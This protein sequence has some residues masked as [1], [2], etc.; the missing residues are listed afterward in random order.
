MAL[1]AVGVFFHRLSVLLSAH[2]QSFSKYNK[3]LFLYKLP[4]SALKLVV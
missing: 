2:S 3:K 4:T 1:G